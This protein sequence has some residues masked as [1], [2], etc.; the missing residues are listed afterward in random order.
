MGNFLFDSDYANLAAALT[1][2]AGRVLVISQNH[3]I[4]APHTV[5]PN[6]HLLGDGGSI[7]ILDDDENVLEIGGDGVTI[8]GIEIVGTGSSPPDP[9]DVT[10]GNGIY[11]EECEDSHRQGLPRPRLQFLR[12]PADRLPRREHP[13]QPALRQYRPARSGRHQ[14]LFQHSRRRPHLH[15]GQF[16]PVEQ[17]P[18]HL[19]HRARP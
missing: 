19:R 4:S 14:P 17:Q 6:T 2:A 18:G 5:P 11:A 7:T 12:N 1:A 8:E 9:L 13:R 10:Q 3:A 16:L 15:R